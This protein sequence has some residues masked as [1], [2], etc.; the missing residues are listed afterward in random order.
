MALFA[1]GAEASSI[2]FGDASK[3]GSRALTLRGRDGEEHGKYSSWSELASRGGEK[4]DGSYLSDVIY[5]KYGLDV[6]FDYAMGEGEDGFSFL[7]LDAKRSEKSGRQQTILGFEFN[8]LREGDDVMTLRGP[9]DGSEREKT[10]D[11]YENYRMIATTAKIDAAS[12]RVDENWA[13]VRE[14]RKGES[15]GTEVV[16]DTT[17]LGDEKLPVT[18]LMR[19]AE[20]ERVVVARYD[21]YKEVCDYYGGR[22]NIPDSMRIGFAATTGG[23]GTPTAM[24]SSFSVVD[25][26]TATPEPSSLAM[27]FGGLVLA[28]LVRRR[29]RA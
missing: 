9:G 8:R 7:V 13:K 29:K 25:A 6:N 12:M 2:S 1:G 10:E 11:G 18:V 14:S 4:S 24:T 20:G 16:V 28:G 19:T 27:G 26:G 21:A 5:T 17:R 23:G 15:Q 22:E 3:E